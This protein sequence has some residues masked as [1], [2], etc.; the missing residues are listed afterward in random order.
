[1]AVLA[2]GGLALLFPI[3][4]I[5]A[6][7]LLHIALMNVVAPLL[8]SV[9][10]RALPP[11]GRSA[12]VWAATIA[13]ILLLWLWHGPPALRAA[14]GSMW[15]S[16]AMH[17][18]LFAVALLFWLSSIRLP[19]RNSWQAICALLVTGKLACLLG[20]L[21]IFAPRALYEAGH[22]GSHGA[23]ALLDDQQLA[24]LYMITA[25]PLSFV[26]AGVIM[27]AQAINHLGRPAP[28]LVKYPT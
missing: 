8:A 4:P 5:S 21:L 10:A 23:H 27:A 26:L 2:A 15:I 12:L 1:M 22:A 14:A 17:G 24:G 13:Q 11:T 25:C 19:A 7:M 18:S 6:H 3:G 16:F 9:L 28:A 20:V